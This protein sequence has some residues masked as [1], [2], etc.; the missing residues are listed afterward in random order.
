MY[1]KTAKKLC[2]TFVGIYDRNINGQ[3]SQK[4]QNSVNDLKMIS[5]YNKMLS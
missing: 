3:N 4:S 2:L 1:H 5:D